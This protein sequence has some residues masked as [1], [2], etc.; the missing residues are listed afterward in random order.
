MTTYLGKSCP[1]GLPRLP[2]VNVCQLMYLVISRL[3]LTLGVQVDE[4][5][6]WNNPFQQVSKKVSSNLNTILVIRRT[7][8]FMLPIVCEAS[9]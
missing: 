9:S 4:N 5:L 3:V 6:M 2:F 8:A 1:V 7:Q